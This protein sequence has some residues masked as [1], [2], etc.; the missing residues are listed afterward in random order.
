[1]RTE[2]KHFTEDHAR[3]GLGLEAHNGAGNRSQLP[4]PAMF[5]VGGATRI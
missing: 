1:M 3:F 5:V 2:I 4:V